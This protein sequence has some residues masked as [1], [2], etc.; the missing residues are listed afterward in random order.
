VKDADHVATVGENRKLLVLRNT[1]RIV[2]NEVRQ[3]T[4]DRP[5][6]LTILASRWLG[7][8]TPRVPPKRPRRTTMVKAP[9][10]AAF[11]VALAF[12]PVQA[13]DN[14][15]WCTDAHMKVMDGKVAAMTDATKKKSAQTHL[16]ASKAAMKAGDTKGCVDHMKEAHKDMGL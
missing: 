13:Q 16:D 5:K 9:L 3:G 10:F 2:D 6:A 11:V 8:Q 7:T 1:T 15:D 4:N 14:K 12:A